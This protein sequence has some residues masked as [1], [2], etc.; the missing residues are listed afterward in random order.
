M[1]DI[2][3]RHQA[4]A[5]RIH[6]EALLQSQIQAQTNYMILT[7]LEGNFTYLNPGF[8]AKFGCREDELLG[9]CQTRLDSPISLNIDF[10]D[11]I[12]KLYL[13]PFIRLRM[14]GYQ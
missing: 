2:T 12:L 11:P 14:L 7:D 8:L 5:E 6:R 4:E 3:P 10:N 9:K 1:Q 13:A